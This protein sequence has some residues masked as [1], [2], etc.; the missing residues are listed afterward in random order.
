ALLKK[1]DRLKITANDIS[2]DALVLAKKNAHINNVFDKLQVF[3]G[4]LFAAIDSSVHFD[5]IVS[6]PPY[7]DPAYSKRLQPELKFE[8]KNALFSDNKGRKLPETI[9]EMAPAYLKKSGILFMEIAD[10]NSS[11]L[12]QK[13]KRFFTDAKIIQDHNSL[14]RFVIAAYP[15]L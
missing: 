5:F 7:I 15:R 12:M 1:I 3:Q 2:Y 10:Y 8:P 4:D 13:A 6:N 9:I 14:N 11:Y